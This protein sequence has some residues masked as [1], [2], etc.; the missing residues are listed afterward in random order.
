MIG[1]I[2]WLLQH[3]HEDEE[4]AITKGI[5]EL[6]R[7]L[8][9][10]EQ[11]SRQ[12][13]TVWLRAPL[14]LPEVEPKQVSDEDPTTAQQRRTSER[15]EQLQHQ[16]DNWQARGSWSPWD[17]QQHDHEWKEWPPGGSSSSSSWQRSRQ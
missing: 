3:L 6:C 4:V 16:W 11:A 8:A 5:H 1:T 15:V 2:L 13:W 12:T 10:Q 9:E 7:K 17:D 14:K